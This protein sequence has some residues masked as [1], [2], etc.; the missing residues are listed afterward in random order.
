MDALLSATARKRPGLFVIGSGLITSALA[1]VLVLFTSTDE[2]QFMTYYINFIS[3]GAII[4]G[5]IAG[6]GYYAASRWTGSKVPTSFLWLIVCLQAAAYV[7]VQYVDYIQ[8]GPRSSGGRLA[9]FLPYF[10][11]VTRSIAFESSGASHGNPVGAWGYA[12]RALE[13]TTFVVAGVVPSLLL[14]RRPYCADCRAYMRTQTLCVIP[15]GLIPRKI[16]KRNTEELAAY[17]DSIHH[18]LDAGV[19]VVDRVRGFAD[20]GA[21]EEFRQLV[22]QLKGQRKAASNLTGRIELTLACCPRCARS[23]IQPTVLPGRGRPVKRRKLDP[24][25]VDAAFVEQLINRA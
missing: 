13:L 1:A 22:E 23:H 5:L 8:F 16:S 4:I 10:D 17:Q 19:R 11:R 2:F 25:E 20:S 9:G 18:T 3:A 12:F 6:S 7:A 24:I 15:A 14:R 21:V